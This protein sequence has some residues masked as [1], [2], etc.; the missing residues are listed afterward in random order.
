VGLLV[1][2]VPLLLSGL[3][4]GSP[5]TPATRTPSH[6]PVTYSTRVEA[7][8]QVWV[9]VE[10]DSDEDIEVTS[11]V[12]S[13]YDAAGRLLQ[14][15]TLD[16]ESD[17]LVTQDAAASFGPLQGPDGWDTV[18]VKKVYYDSAPSLPPPGRPVA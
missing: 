14:K 5:A 16:C 13:F 3:A 6:D 17:C 9:D 12:V 15:A 8:Q 10:N 11:V 2:L 7:S 1:T 4:A 18:D